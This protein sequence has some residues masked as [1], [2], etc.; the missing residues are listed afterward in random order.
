MAKKFL[1]HIDMNKNEIQNAVIQNL[2]SAPGTPVEG[3]VYYDT[4]DD[5][6]YLYQAGGF[7]KILN[8]ADIV[9]STS[10]TG[11]SNSNVPSTTAVKTYVDNLLAGLR[12]HEQVRVAS[13]ANVDISTGLENGDT[14]DGVTLATG[15]RVLL[16]DQTAGA[17]N[18]VYVVVASGA[19]SRATAENSEAELINT[20]YFV[21]EGTANGDTAWTITNNTITLETTAI[22]VSQFGGSSVPQATTTTQGKVELATEAEVIAK[23][24]PD[25]AVTPAGLA[26]F[27]RKYTGTISASSGATITAATHGLGATKNLMVQI[28][29]DGGTDNNEIAADITVQD[30][31]DVVWATNTA[32]SGHI[33]IIG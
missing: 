4:D 10:L 27:P 1:T 31:G 16:K 15:D 21:K 9:T 2:A 17:E 3:Q 22:V 32:I 6:V 7:T 14:L 23:S 20:A 12:W 24:D 19:A 26:T 25:R 11:A 8:A 13:T 30:D 33:V 28:F 18:G 5:S 29:E